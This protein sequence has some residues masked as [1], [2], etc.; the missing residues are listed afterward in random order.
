VLYE[1]HLTEHAREVRTNMLLKIKLHITTTV[2]LFLS[3]LAIALLA[4]GFFVKS[5]ISNNGCDIGLD[6]WYYGLSSYFLVATI[7]QC[8]RFVHYRW[9]N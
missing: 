7:I 2:L 1:D 5:T 4:N 6:S 8:A 9:H 3:S